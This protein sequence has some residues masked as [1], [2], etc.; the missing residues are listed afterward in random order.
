MFL[1][2]GDYVYIEVCEIDGFG[3][4]VYVVVD[5]VLL[6]FDL[7]V[8][9]MEKGL[10]VVCMVCGWFGGMCSSVLVVRWC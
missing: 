2:V 9:S 5:W 6:V 4:L 3:S 8:R 1:V 7:R 10:V